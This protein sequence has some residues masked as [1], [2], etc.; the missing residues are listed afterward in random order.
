MSVNIKR[1]PHAET[2]ECDRCIADRRHEQLMGE[3][4]QLSTYLSMLVDELR[5]LRSESNR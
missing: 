2:C 5:A 3:L 1:E 4:G